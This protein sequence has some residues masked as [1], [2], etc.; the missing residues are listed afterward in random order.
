MHYGNAVSHPVLVFSLSGSI[1][2]LFPLRN[3]VAGTVSNG[4]RVFIFLLSSHVVFSSISN[5]L[6]SN[7]CQH[8]FLSETEHLK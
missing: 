4:F 1:L 8:P 2:F 3:G 7:L 5:L 6:L